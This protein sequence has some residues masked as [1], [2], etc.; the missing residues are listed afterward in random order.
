MPSLHVKQWTIYTVQINL[1][2]LNSY[3]ENINYGIKLD[4]GWIRM[5]PDHD[6]PVDEG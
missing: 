4:M 1:T 6:H 5:R 2:L 3:G